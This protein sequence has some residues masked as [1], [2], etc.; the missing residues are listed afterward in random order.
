[1]VC[2]SIWTN[3]EIAVVIVHGNFGPERHAS[4]RRHA[5]GMLSPLSDLNK[6]YM[7]VGVCMSVPPASY[8][9]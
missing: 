1:M 7:L 6:R 9:A 2:V 4:A 3:G 5:P 8:V